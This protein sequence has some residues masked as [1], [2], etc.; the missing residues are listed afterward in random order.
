MEKKISLIRYKLG[1]VIMKYVRLI[2]M[3]FAACLLLCGC[4]KTPE[5]VK[6]NM[7][8]YG[9]NS[10]IGHTEVTYCSVDE[11]KNKK[12]SAI[13]TGNVKIISDAD[14]SDVE[15]V[16][17]LQLSFEQNF[18]ADTNIE[19]YTK[20]FGVNKE[21]L[22]NTE[23]GESDWGRGVTYDNEKEQKYLDMIENGGMSYMADSLYEGGFDAIESKYNVDKEDISNVNIYLA[24]KEANLSDLC[25]N[26]EKWLEDNMYI[27]GLN[28]K[29]S[30]AFITK[31]S[32]VD[33]ESRAVSICAEC[34]YKGIRFNDYTKPLIKNNDDYDQE[35]FTTTAFTILRY[36]DNQDIPSYFSRNTNFVLNSSKPIEKIIDPESAV[37]ILKNELSGFGIFEVSEAIPLY[38]LYLKDH[39]ESPGAGIE[40][41]PVYAFLVKDTNMASDMS[42]GIGTIKMN[43]YKHF[44]FI[45][46]ETGELTT[47]LE[48]FNK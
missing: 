41:R 13:D 25:K 10:Q 15:A 48:A 19:K 3:I 9:E 11:L 42:S 38:A 31:K 24:D 17:I 20:L 36:Y 44:F 28:Y 46:M 8:K 23:A 33:T 22:N 5:K 32:D 29:V 7:E 27:A 14:F 34:E 47:D 1:D 18:I 2:Y 43:Y 16:D 37:R 45:D 26:A 39:S 4:Q 12:L 6:E 35:V 40:A 30:D 21:K